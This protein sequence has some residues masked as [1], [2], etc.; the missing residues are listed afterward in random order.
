[1]Q[2]YEANFELQVNVLRILKMRVLIFE[3]CRRAFFYF[4]LHLIWMFKNF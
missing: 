2:G 4:D 3:F 1:M